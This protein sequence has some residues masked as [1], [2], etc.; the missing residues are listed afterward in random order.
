[1]RGPAGADDWVGPWRKP[2]QSPL[3]LETERLVIR[4]WEPGDAGALFRVVDEHRAGLGRWLPWPANYREP[5][6]AAT[7]IAGTVA[8]HADP[9]GTDGSFALIDRSSGAIVGGTGF[10]AGVN[11]G[12][13]A[14]YANAGAGSVSFGYWVRPDMHNRGLCTEAMSAHVSALLREQGDG[15]WG[16]RRAGMTCDERNGASAAIAVKLG[17]RLEGRFHEDARAES[18]DGW[19]STLAF[20]VVRSEWDFDA[21]RALGGIQRPIV[22]PGRDFGPGFGA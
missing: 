5:E 2:G 12:D 9:E 21:G 10:H 4:A 17:L 19:R 22:V 20:G 16:F 18:G 7:W 13:H 1:M 14:F 8:Q 11:I 6:D 3:P 15:G